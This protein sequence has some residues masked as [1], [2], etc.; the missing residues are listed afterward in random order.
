MQ[1]MNP[2]SSTLFKGIHYKTSFSQHK[3]WERVQNELA[4]DPAI[5]LNCIWVFYLLEAREQKRKEKEVSSHNI[6]V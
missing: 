4:Q 6:V 2:Q 1:R 5:D 3:I